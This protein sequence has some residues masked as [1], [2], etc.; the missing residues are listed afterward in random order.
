M[1]DI[2]SGG[3]IQ[4]LPIVCSQL[5]AEELSIDWFNLPGNNDLGRNVKKMLRKMCR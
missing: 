5:G 1:A 2:C 4:S 3:A